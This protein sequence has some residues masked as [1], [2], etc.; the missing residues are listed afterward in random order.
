MERWRASGEVDVVAGLSDF[1]GNES[2]LD[3]ERFDRGFG[4]RSI[5]YSGYKGRAEHCHLS[6][7]YTR[8]YT[9]SR[10]NSM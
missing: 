9:R 4:K 7:Y 2:H 6:V 5:A 10:G 8:P 3:V 1:C